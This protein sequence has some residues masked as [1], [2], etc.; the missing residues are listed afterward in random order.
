M[1]DRFGRNI[2]GTP[3]CFDRIILFC[4]FKPICHPKAIGFALFEAGFKLLGYEKKFA[5]TLCLQIRDHIKRGGRTRRASDKDVN[6]DVRKKAL[7]S[8]ILS[9][10]RDDDCI[11]CILSAMEKCSCFKV[12]KKTGEMACLIWAAP[13]LLDLNGI[14]EHIAL[15]D[16]VAASKTV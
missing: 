13:A 16:P 9:E 7:V 5:N 12:G 6:F 1:T 10:R 2:V 4:T 3:N 15:D 8:Q 14:A 11:A